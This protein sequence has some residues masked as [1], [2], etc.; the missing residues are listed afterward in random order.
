MNLK[1]LNARL[2]SVQD[3]IDALLGTA[4]APK[5]DLSIEDVDAAKALE[6][7]KSELLANVQALKDAE[8]LRKKNLQ[9]ARRAGPVQPAKVEV[10]GEAWE[11][12][13]DPMCGFKEPKDMLKAVIESGS[14]HGTDP[15][16]KML[17]AGSDEGMV[18]S[19]PYGG[20]AVPSGFMASLLTRDSEVD[21][22]QPLTTKIPMA[23]PTVKIPARVDSTHTSSVSGGLTVSRRAETAA[24]T[25]SRMQLE[26]VTLNAHSLFGL[27]YATEELLADS[28]I[29]WI[30][31]LQAGFGEEFANRK[32]HERINGTGAGEFEGVK[33]SA[34]EI[35]VARGTDSTFVLLDAANMISRCYRSQNAVWMINPTVIP[36][37]VTMSETGTG[38][39]LVNTGSGTGTFSLLGRPVYVTEHLP[40]LNTEGDVM[41]VNWSEYLEGDLETKQ[42]ASSTHVRFVEHERCFKFYERNDARCWWRAALTPK[43]GSTISPIVTLTDD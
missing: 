32:I 13:E 9:R 11:R 41:L 15:R 24:G 42:F 37:L 34:A 28:A 22:I 10:L 18:A 20:F 39:A 38:S 29:S 19:D 5:E 4:A 2:D 31:T 14:G 36:Q 33:A 40:A 21:F 30:A 16:L 8:E 27:S 25:S 1:D 17:A 43:N 3:E 12:G 6:A 7:E 23:T 26:Q 35:T